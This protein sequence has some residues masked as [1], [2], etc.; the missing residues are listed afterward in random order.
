MAPAYWARIFPAS[1]IGRWI[2]GPSA[3]GEGVAGE[4][5]GKADGLETGQRRQIDVGI[6]IGM[7]RFAALGRRIDPGARRQNVGT[8]ARRSAGRVAGSGSAASSSGVGRVM[9]A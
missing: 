4:K 6:E 5:I 2:A 3:H 8:A 7:R 9:V 1:K